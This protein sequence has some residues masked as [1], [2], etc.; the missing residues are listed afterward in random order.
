MAIQARA[1]QRRAAYQLERGIAADGCDTYV[2]L[3]LSCLVSFRL[4]LSRPVSSRL[5]LLYIVFYM[6][7]CRDDA[8]LRVRC[9]L[10]P[11]LACTAAS[12]L[13]H[14]ATKAGCVFLCLPLA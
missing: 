1:A 10:L 8:C 2:E 11:T 3:V 12:A 9:R 13:E 4:V 7:S 14:T 6:L 5:F